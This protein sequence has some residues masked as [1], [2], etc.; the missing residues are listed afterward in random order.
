MNKRAY[1]LVFDRQRGM[2]V[3]AS[4]TARSSGKAAGQTRLGRLGATAL[5]AAVLVSGGAV[6]DPAEAQT[7]RAAVKMARDYNF[8]QRAP[9]PVRYTGADANRRWV[10]VD[11]EKQVT[12]LQN[13]QTLTFDHTRI[14]R[15]IVNL[16]S[17][18][19]APGYT[20]NV[21]QNA[22]PSKS[23]SA[24]FKVWDS[25]NPSLILGTLK[26]NREVIIQNANGVLFGR[27]A[28][29]DTGAFVATALSIADKTFLQG[30][31]KGTDASAV[32][33]TEGTDH[34]ATKLDAVV[35][36]E[37]GVVIRAAAGGDVMLVAPRVINQGTIET[38][39]GQTILAAGNKVYLASS[40]DNAQRG[41]I[42][43]V[44]PIFYQP[45]KVVK[46]ENGNDVTV[47]DG[48]K[49]IDT[50]LGIVE[51]LAQGIDQIK[52]SSGQV[53]LVGLLVKQNG[54]IRATTAVKG[55]NGGIYLQGQSSTVAVSRAIAEQGGVKAYK[56]VSTVRL[57]QDLGTVVLGNGSLTEITPDNGS[58]TQI[59]AETF[60]R[61][62]IRAE[63]KLVQVQSG[64]TLSAPGG[65][66]S[67]LAASKVWAGVGGAIGGVSASGF[68]LDTTVNT[69]LFNTADD[70]SRLLVEAGATLN[71]GGLRGVAVDG[72]RYQGDM[73]L[74]R[75][76]L[77]DVPL[78]RA[79][80]LYR[81]RALF[82]LRGSADIT[83]ANVKAAQAA[84]G[85]T[86]QELSSHGGTLVLD[87]EGLLMVDAG[88][89]LNVQGGSIKVSESNIRTSGLLSKRQQKS[90][91]VNEAKP[92]DVYD[93]LITPT[94]GKVVAGYT[95]G[96]KGGSALFSGRT[97]RFEGSVQAD[98]V[99][100][101]Y[102]R[103]LEIDPKA[104]TDRHAS[105]TFGRM[106]L[107]GTGA[108]AVPHFKLGG[109]NLSATG[110]PQPDV[111]AELRANPTSTSYVGLGAANVPTSTL[112]AWG[113]GHLSLAAASISQSA[114][115]NLT[116]LPG[117][118]LSMAAHELLLTGRFEA[119][120]GHI[121][122]NTYLQLVGETLTRGSLTLATGSSLDASGLFTND[123][124]RFGNGN[125]WVMTQGGSVSLN[126]QGDLNAAGSAI[127]VSAGAHV[128][129]VTAD[130]LGGAGSITLKAGADHK[131]TE[132]APVAT[133]AL[134]IQN[135][136]LQGFDFKSGGTLTLQAPNLTVIASGAAAS[137]GFA[138]S[139]DF[140]SQ[141]GFG[142][143]DVQSAGHVVVKADV[144][145]QPVL[146]TWQLTTKADQSGSGVMGSQVVNT[147]ADFNQSAKDRKPVNVSLQATGKVSPV[148]PDFLGSNLTVE[149]GA[150]IKL[151]AGGTLT[152]GATGNLHIG[153]ATT[154][155]EQKDGK[156]TTLQALGGKV[157]LKLSGTRGGA[158]DTDDRIGFLAD[159]AIWIGSKTVIDVSGTADKRDLVVKAKDRRTNRLSQL[160]EVR[161]EARADDG[162]AAVKTGEIFAGGTISLLA[163]RGH[164]VAESG[165][166]LK[167]D[168][169]SERMQLAGM[170]QPQTITLG[171]GTLQIGAAEGFA[172]EGTVSAKGIKGGDGGKLIADMVFNTN[173]FNTFTGNASKPYPTDLR[174]MVVGAD[175]Q[176]LAKAGLMAGGNLQTAMGNGKG[177][178]SL[179]LLTDSG[180][181]SAQLSARDV[182]QFAAQPQPLSL[183]MPMGL[184]LHAPVLALEQGVG[185]PPSVTLRSNT[186]VSLG[187]AKDVPGLASAT[188]GNG[189]LVVEAPTIDIHGALALQ[190]VNNT[191][192][193]AQEVRLVGRG[194]SA[195]RPTG[196]LG[197]GGTLN[198]NT[199][200]LYTTNASTF[201]VQGLG[202]STLAA[203]GQGS[204]INIERLNAFSSRPM[205]LSA[206]GQLTLQAQDI[207]Q[208]GVIHQPFGAIELLGTDRVTLGAQ[209]VTSVSAKGGLL[210]GG[211]LNNQT[212]WNA[213]AFGAAFTTLPQDK[214]ITIKGGVEYKDSPTAVVD[215]SAGG[216]LQTREWFPGV[217]G[218]EDY[219]QK[220]G[221]YAVLPD[222][223]NLSTLKLGGT[224]DTASPK[225]LVITTPGGLLAPG[226]YTLL[227]AH[228]ALLANALP[229]G[230]FM[231]SVTNAQSTPLSQPYQRLDGS[232][233][234]SG[235][236][237]DAG[238]NSQGLVPSRI[239]V[240]GPGTF[241]AKAEYRTTSVTEFF[242]QRAES[243]G[244][245]LVR[246]PNDAGQVQIQ[247]GSATTGGLVSANIRLNGDADSAAGLLDI[248]AGQLSLTDAASA[249]PTRFEVSASSLSQ[250]G[251]GSIMLGA[252]RSVK[253]PTDT[254]NKTVVTVDA[255]T[256]ATTTTVQTQSPLSV[257]EL[258][259]LG[260]T[261]VAVADGA[262]ISATGQAPGGVTELTLSGDSALLAVSNKQNL[263]VTRT[264]VDATNAT[265]AN[266]SLV[267]LTLGNNVTL[268]GETVSL[269]TTRRYNLAPSAQI[270]ARQLQLSA[271]KLQVGG[272][273]T[274]ASLIEGSLKDAALAAQRLSLRS[275]STIEFQGLQDWAASGKVFERLAIDAAEVRGTQG[276][277]VKL[278]AQ[279]IDLRNTS[280][281]TY[282]SVDI[283]KGS[284]ELLAT[285]ALRQGYT[286][287]IRKGANT[288]H[289]AFDTATLASTGDLIFEA[290][291]T[292]NQLTAQKDLSIQASRLTAETR[293]V[294]TVSAGGKLSLLQSLKAEGAH[295]LG[296]HVGQAAQISFKGEQILQDSTLDFKSG[297]LRFE[298]T[299][300]NADAHNIVFGQNSSTSAK[301]F[302]LDAQK[303]WQ[304]HGGG[305]SILVKTAA[306]GV[307]LLGELDVGASQQG[308]AG[309]VDIKTGWISQGEQ[310]RIK[311]Q[312]GQASDDLG[313]RLNIDVN[314]TSSS[315]SGISPASL[316]D[317]ARLAQGGGFTDA[318]TL[319]V[320]QEDQNLTQD[321][322]A[323]RITLIADGGALLVNAALTGG[324]TGGGKAELFAKNKITLGSQSTLTGQDI[325]LASSTS[326]I[327]AQQARLLA[328]EAGRV[329]FR[330]LRNGT[331]G[332][333]STKPLTDSKLDLSRINAA[334]VVLEGVKVFETT[335]AL[336]MNTAYLNTL[337]TDS[338]N[339]LNT[340]AD[341]YDKLSIPVDKRGTQ[342]RLEAGV[343]VQATGN[344][345]LSNDW[346]L[347][348]VSDT[349]GMNSTLKDLSLAA[350]APA[351]KSRSATGLAGTVTLRA[352]GNLDINAN[353]SD[354]FVN[355]T[356]AKTLSNA[357][358]NWSYRLVG[359]ANLNSAHV[360]ATQDLADATTALG[361]VT[362]GSNKVVRT[363]D[364]S[365]DIA[366][367]QH[368][369]LAGSTSGTTN[370][371]ASVYVAGRKLETSARVNS[372]LG[373]N[374]STY[375]V[376]TPVLTTGGRQ[377][378]VTARGNI[379]AGTPGQLAG[380]W[381]IARG[382]SLGDGTSTTGANH[383]AWWTNLDLFKQSLLSV[384]GIE[385]NAGKAITDVSVSVPT[386]A[387]AEGV[388][389]DKVQPTDKDE[390]VV[391]ASA[392]W[393]VMNGGDITVR[394]GADILGGSYFL[395]K[396]RAVIETQ[397]NFASS[398]TN[399]VGHH[400][401][402]LIDGDI[403]VNAHGN[404]NATT[405]FNPTAAGTTNTLRNIRDYYFSYTSTAAFGL[406][407]LGGD[408]NINAFSASDMASALGL[409]TTPGANAYAVTAP[410]LSI[411][412]LG[413]ALTLAKTQL[414]L[415]PSAQGNLKLYAAGDATILG[416]SL[417]DAAVGLPTQAA[418]PL[419]TKSSATESKT[420]VD[421]AMASAINFN[422]TSLHAQDTEPVRLAVGGTLKGT[423]LNT[424]TSPKTAIITAEG[425]ILNFGFSGQHHQPGDVSLIQ[426]GRNIT[427]EGVDLNLTLGGPGLLQ[428]KAGRQLDLGASQ[429]I[430]S[431]GNANNPSL[432]VLGASIEAASGTATTV[433][434]AAFQG[435]YLDA[436]SNPRA[437]AHQQAL[438]DFVRQELALPALSGTADL[439]AAYAE[440]LAQFSRFTP[441]S[442]SELVRQVQAREFAAQY[443]AAGSVPSQ[444]AYAAQLES[445][446]NR[447]KAL[448]LQGMQTLQNELNRVAQIGDARERAR[449]TTE[450]LRTV[451]AA[452]S[453]E[454]KGL[455]AL[456]LDPSAS[457]LLEASAQVKAFE[458]KLSRLRFS[459]LD[460][461][462]V[463][464]D[465]VNALAAHAQA[466]PEF[467]LSALN[468]T[469]TQLETLRTQTEPSE[470]DRRLLQKVDQALNLQ[471]TDLLQRY[472]ALRM[473]TE[474]ESVGINVSKF[475]VNTWPMLPTLF[476][477]GYRWLELAGVG[478]FST[479]A[480]WPGNQNVLNHAGSIQMVSS[481]IQT[482]AGGDIGMLAAGGVLNVGTKQ[483]P[484]VTQRA[485][486]V[487]GMQGGN[488]NSISRD[489]QQVGNER[490]F[491]LGKGDIL[492]WSSLRDLD[493]GRGSNS[494]V[495]TGALTPRRTRDGVVFET[496]API[497]G[498]GIGV[499]DGATPADGTAFL[500]APLGRVLA[501][502][503]FI[504]APAFGI[505]GPVLGS[506]NLNPSASGGNVAPVAAPALNI[507][508]PA[509]GAAEQAQEE[510]K[511]K[512]KEGGNAQS[513]MTVE[514]LGLGDGSAP[515]AGPETA[516]PP[517]ESTRAAGPQ[518]DDDKKKKKP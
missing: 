304:V 88:A 161:Q 494:A 114:A 376:G 244:T 59:D 170:V 357:R 196:S 393:V 129:L 506:D 279:D 216:S 131:A 341:V 486:G 176:T 236:V 87:S 443:L 20:F 363:G 232:Q 133:K 166:S 206:F 403:Q 493:S 408:M 324:L 136:V 489:E 366:A 41:L 432:P 497:N 40:A 479:S 266:Q 475:A 119:H 490:I 112:A 10:T 404:L 71:V 219:L 355:T 167:L 198:I 193:S 184:S 444:A 151:E 411:E 47:N 433:N 63:G 502:D 13:G 238:G 158:S 484:N 344:I 395:G 169:V 283:G 251:A 160:A 287:G 445:E 80:P 462:G 289:L 470:A 78:Q 53:N 413:G 307:S 438:I 370:T 298:A 267:Q 74:F 305:G 338:T 76:E 222:H 126:A 28:V 30:L 518:A 340:A 91:L 217:G 163:E 409:A 168:G 201:K 250:T 182:I 35:A 243:L 253:P 316:N 277:Q 32:F 2:K 147:I 109:I 436:A 311:G 274:S 230:A 291:G 223:A 95:E 308:H 374:P 356:D 320:G 227:P 467:V 70:G 364:A 272:A 145:L 186:V 208:N 457:A 75:V 210:P 351:V 118:S 65:D 68:A 378:A 134:N 511:G 177:L 488:I 187:N 473:N 421:A 142:Q 155:L 507:A 115:D 117:G 281:L 140:F 500:L 492:M 416:L 84:L 270:Q 190:G 197:F 137:A 241:N 460:T 58:A 199:D 143:F 27:G 450:L 264:G 240:E 429:G 200:L 127:N 148:A 228:L 156:T 331:D 24:M 480:W 419:S 325:L 14:D 428:V 139:S 212:T 106:F 390:W 485:R 297:V 310:T 362:V 231:V 306:G 476:S 501:L 314:Q 150:S 349:A 234:L 125:D 195:A 178:V 19:I 15:I 447:F 204:V 477:E 246:L 392:D 38:T 495:A 516:A 262:S 333:T 430:A 359:G 335:G 104:G 299:S 205:P 452:L 213:L 181:S 31:R 407:S 424:L 128:S 377:L 56:D 468:V 367:G 515:A 211:F 189:Q 481:A 503:A 105:V 11:Q 229:Q 483:T 92:D 469:P 382:K 420:A 315:T 336:T 214:R 425:D 312:A 465:R 18:D 54:V 456:L 62:R 111:L 284:F 402:A 499:L 6:H 141:G 439:Q 426:A 455:E 510:A 123:S 96:N 113:A 46:D 77:A 400:G 422:A 248:T 383:P 192:L 326:S 153:A 406:K 67:L 354:G 203:R 3:P 49:V 337:N 323:K 343:E 43:A 50:E 102:Q 321:L 245:P 339:Y 360:M 379:T 90:L 334:E 79:G 132:A 448:Q 288:T 260:K 16:E 328:G 159:Q 4:E 220:E 45:T 358:N 459:S 1:R 263:V 405:A 292:N 346:N 451:P 385:V 380:Q 293:A 365:I 237:I 17:L 296:E 350:T 98:V 21:V 122:L 418:L 86:A 82:D 36:T 51:N 317:L 23:V 496:P 265:D 268:R 130:A 207:T 434:L 449:Q 48:P 257:Q 352:G 388:L 453:N 94:D 342:V 369:V 276:T 384:S 504:R 386:Q 446:F 85:R 226:T 313:G 372:M 101:T 202:S 209:S 371:N 180:F 295:T 505:P 44:D 252:W 482:L 269:D 387:Y 108:E 8:G 152:L 368:V 81:Q 435:Q 172:I 34:L 437:R 280:G 397:G 319:R 157:N 514:L 423:T 394:A 124:P 345:T 120:G 55:Q 224:Q 171:A 466:W 97:M 322:T 110:S 100:G 286:G 458:T 273:S 353:L 93:E 399:A 472:Q 135:A 454:A 183:S 215:A 179:G 185:A 410:K 329:K 302:A 5:A 478:A 69:G 73:R 285:P 381:F 389:K 12:W 235:S 332:T 60:S 7:R 347:N 9:L 498:S 327:D 233:W 414:Y 508:A 121:K 401:F 61:S 442:Q 22:D 294:Q 52:A 415:Y 278:A 427:Q 249:E 398:T 256:L 512:A 318:V 138:L 303:G 464:Q 37:P 154:A 175:A 42:V 107:I 116:L 221:L 225:Q 162:A 242:K 396:G 275:L 471:N 509:A 66:I 146:Q 165:S 191:R 290:G 194:P 259:V 491:T 57:G 440:A 300:T 99:R 348:Q 89:T 247:H 188:M 164:V 261:S 33:T 271:R 474:L 441:A 174:Q 26:A 330:A 417:M 149:R 282:K 239:L 375:S 103:N 461:A 301:G 173:N 72:N 361:T 144:A 25:T 391:P 83:V 254:N 309:S 463:V 258:L 255:S 29:V 513:L 487:L 517:T 412:A 431:T 218:S 373:L 39:Q 64:A